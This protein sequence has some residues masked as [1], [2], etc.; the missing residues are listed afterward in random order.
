MGKHEPL[1]LTATALQ[2]YDFLPTTAK[3]IQRS[4]GKY[5]WTVLAVILATA[6]GKE[7]IPVAMGYVYWCCSCI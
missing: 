2:Q 1:S 7:P 3:P 4:N 5:E 6:P